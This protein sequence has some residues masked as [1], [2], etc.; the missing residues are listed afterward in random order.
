[1]LSTGL[2]IG[3]ALL[4]IAAIPAISG[5]AHCREG[6]RTP[7]MSSE[8]YR[9]KS[10]RVVRTG[11]VTMSSTP[12]HNWAKGKQDGAS[13]PRTANEVASAE[14][15]PAHAKSGE[16]YARVYLPPEFDT[17]TERV[18]VREESEKIEIIPAKYDW[19]EERVLVKEASTRL[20]EVPAQFDV[21]DLLVQTS[22][23]HATWVKANQARCVAD[24]PGPPPQDIF[25]FLSE[26]PTTTTIQ[27]ERLVQGPQ[28]KEVTVPAEYQTIRKQKLVRPA[29][30]R[31]VTIPAEF[32][33][34]TKTVMVRPG[35][36]EWRRVT[37]D[38]RAIT[39]NR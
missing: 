30:T 37:C 23:G 39:M 34:V 20:V 21:Q 36:M 1:M 14:D 26:P 16:C 35:K 9:M 7:A 24:T 28:V 33:E 22:P 5:C 25:C 38:S 2:K 31:K 8:G 10:P 12:N 17:V 11:R 3:S 13:A 6:T 19:V 15:M 27:T 18:C 32:R 29:T 4:C